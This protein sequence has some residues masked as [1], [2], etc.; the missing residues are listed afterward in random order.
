MAAAN[1][2]IKKSALSFHH[3]QI[4]ANILKFH[5]YQPLSKNNYKWEVLCLKQLNA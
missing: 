5:T 1:V 4:P 2:A 3:I